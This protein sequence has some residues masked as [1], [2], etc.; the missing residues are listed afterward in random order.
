ML[1][2]LHFIFL[3][4]FFAF[5]F[6]KVLKMLIFKLKFSM[7]KILFSSPYSQWNSFHV[8]FC[9]FLQLL[10]T[11]GILGLGLLVNIAVTQDLVI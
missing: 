10:T 11:P 9:S 8:S 2:M 1:K 6:S 3:L 5:Y 7:C 4:F